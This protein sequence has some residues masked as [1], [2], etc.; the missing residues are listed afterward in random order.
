MTIYM[1]NID[2]KITKRIITPALENQKDENVLVN[3]FIRDNKCLRSLFL[4]NCQ[5]EKQDVEYFPTVFSQKDCQIQ[6][7]DLS[8]NSSV[9]EDG[10][11]EIGK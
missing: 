1:I 8:L 9:G 5:F 7:L 3:N 2:G 6:H 10:L 11:K 4:K